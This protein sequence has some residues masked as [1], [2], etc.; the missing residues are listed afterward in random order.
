MSTQ[1]DT[2]PRTGA[3]HERP[4]EDARGF[5]LVHLVACCV[6]GGVALVAVILIQWLT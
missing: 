3:S 4:S 5:G 1:T 6:G 2:R